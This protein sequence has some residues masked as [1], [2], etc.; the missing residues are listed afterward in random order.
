[1]IT[2]S[3]AFCAAILY[4]TCKLNFRAIRRPFVPTG[5]RTGFWFLEHTAPVSMAHTCTH[6]HL[7]DGV[8]WPFVE[9]RWLSLLGG[10]GDPR[11]ARLVRPSQVSSGPRERPCHHPILQRWCI[12]QLFRSPQGVSCGVRPYAEGERLPGDQTDGHDAHQHQVPARHL[13]YVLVIF[14]FE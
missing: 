13:A 11:E 4:Y 8:A 12:G 14:L 1:M 5:V 9:L 3:A 7:L 10:R 2:C 6:L